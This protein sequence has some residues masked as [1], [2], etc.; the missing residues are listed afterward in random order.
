MIKILAIVALDN[1]VLMR[2]WLWIVPIL[3]AVALLQ[4]WISSKANSLIKQWA[5]ANG[6]QLL[7]RERRFVRQGPFSWN[8]TRSQVVYRVVVLD[9]QGNNLTGWIRLGSWWLGLFGNKPA[10][11]VKWNA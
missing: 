1:L 5:D 4:L 7:Q 11:E 8:S 6:Y 9:L 3:M 10:L 2:A